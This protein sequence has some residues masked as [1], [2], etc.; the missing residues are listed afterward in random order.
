VSTLQ[1]W[2]RTRRR[3]AVTVLLATVG[4]VLLTAGLVGL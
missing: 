2:L 1:D 4:C 3:T